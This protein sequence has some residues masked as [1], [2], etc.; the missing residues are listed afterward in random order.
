MNTLGL[1]VPA[2]LLSISMINYPSK[3][4]CGYEVMVNDRFTGDGLT[5]SSLSMN[6]LHQTFHFSINDRS[7]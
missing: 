2:S 5:G 3:Q 1:N 6:D 7:R 4:A